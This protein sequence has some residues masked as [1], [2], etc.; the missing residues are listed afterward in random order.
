MSSAYGLED[1]FAFNFLPGSYENGK[2]SLFAVQYSVDDGTQYGS[3]NWGDVL[4][5]PQK[6]GC[7]DF[8]KP[9]QNL[10]NAFKT[11]NGLPDFDNF[12]NNDYNA[13]TDKTDP[14]LFHT[15]ALPGLPY[16]YNTELIYKNDWNR[17]SNVYGFY[18]SLKENVDPS[19]SC[20]RNINP[21]RNWC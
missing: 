19:C 14:R 6:L 18:A 12:N 17:N 2:E 16:K 13:A 15:V 8:H 21:F 7:C 3:L 20:F 9:S 4:S 5:V 1:D 10:V 11:V